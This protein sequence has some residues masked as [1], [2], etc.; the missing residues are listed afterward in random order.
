MI[1][2]PEE[3]TAQLRALAS[4]VPIAT[5]IPR[6]LWPGMTTDDAVR[7]IDVLGRE[8]LPLIRSEGPVRKGMQ[9]A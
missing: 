4:D 1:G 6:A 5:V 7:Y 9:G 3:C 8:L 2:S